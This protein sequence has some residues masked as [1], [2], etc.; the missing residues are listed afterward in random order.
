[1]PTWSALLLTL[2]VPCLHAQQAP[3]E[4]P[5]SFLAVPLQVDLG[6]LIAAAERTTPRVPP[7]VETWIPLPGMALGSP[8]YRFNLYRDPLFVVVKG[9]RLVVH[10][11]V[12]Y[13]M[14]VGLRMKDWV[15]G[16]GSCGVAPESFRRARLGLQAE[17]ALTPS[18]GLD[19]KITPED[20]LRIDGC[21]VTFLGYDLT[22]R[23]LAGMKDALIK[24]AQG[25]EQQLRDSTLLRQRAEAAWVQAL[26]PV[27]LAPGV[28]LMLNPQR[29]RLSPWTSVGKVLTITPEIQT[30]PTLTLGA[31]PPVQARPLPPLDTTDTLVPPGF[32]VRVEADLSFA[33]ASEQLARQMAGKKFE[34][35]KG[36]FTVVSAAVRGRGELALLELELKGKV[37]G[38]LTL[39]GRPV[40][41]PEAGTLTLEGLDYTLESKSW[42]T[43]F[44]EW[45]YR[46]TLRKTLADQCH[47]FLDRS[48]KDLK[49]QAQ[50]GINR[51]LAPGLTMSGT[52][53]SFT[54]SG[55]E[56]APDRFKVVAQL[57]GQVQIAVKAEL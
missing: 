21:E 27:E 31:R 18:W 56:V 26:E 50:Q 17:L 49:A 2:A 3:L 55:L 42:L 7:G 13:W 47:F 4:P 34:T 35:E 57:A 39:T 20:P 32:Q 30:R 19:L 5:P 33:A 43:S 9:K 44:G 25:L 24:A 52:I 28:Y 23:V 36:T 15:K 8:A 16:M 54:L 40:F 51:T 14:E 38:R 29:I 53:D 37:N 45:L 1:M 41:N 10:T 22:D 12:H 6:P 48:F 46:S 11:T